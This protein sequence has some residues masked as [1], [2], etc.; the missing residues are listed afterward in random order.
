[1][2]VALDSNV[3]IYAEGAGDEVRRRW[4]LSLIAAI[5]ASDLLR[6]PS[7]LSAKR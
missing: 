7:R 2:R 4:A 6:Y 5:R 3:M 1:M